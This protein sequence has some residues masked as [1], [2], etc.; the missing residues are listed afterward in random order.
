MSLRHLLCGAAAVLSLSAAFADDT[1]RFEWDNLVTDNSEPVGP[2]TPLLGPIDLVLLT[3]VTDIGNTGIRPS[4]LT[5]LTLQVW[6]SGSVPGWGG[7]LLSSF[8][9]YPLYYVPQVGGP[10][11]EQLCCDLHIFFRPGDRQ[12]T[13]LDI[14]ISTVESG[15]SL[16]LDRFKWSEG[17][18]GGSFF[19]TFPLHRAE[20]MITE[21]PEPASLSLLLVGLG[22][23]AGWS[24]RRRFGT[25]GLREH[26]KGADSIALKSLTEGHGSMHGA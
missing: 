23:V 7:R 6:G 25:P 16:D 20:P 2:G 4:A 5:H 22:A 3:T 12:F 1:I 8:Q 10:P 21:V 19:Y 24:G 15:A 14:G 9:G 18:G 17:R 11:D 13:L 26:G